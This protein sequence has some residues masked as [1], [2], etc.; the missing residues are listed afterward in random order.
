MTT[1]SF[2]NRSRRFLTPLRPRPSLDASRCVVGVA[3]GAQQRQ[4]LAGYRLDT[5]AEVI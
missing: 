3:R 4:V 2:T 5:S 1:A